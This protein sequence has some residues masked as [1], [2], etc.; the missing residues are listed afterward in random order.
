MLPT[1]LRHLHRHYRHITATITATITA[2]KK[3]TPTFTP[4]KQYQPSAFTD[5][6]LNWSPSQ[7]YPKRGNQEIEVKNRFTPYYIKEFIGKNGGDNIV[8]YQQLKRFIVQ[9][10]A[11][12]LCK[13]RQFHCADCGD[14]I[15]QV[16]AFSLCKLRIYHKKMVFH[17][18]KWNTI[19]LNFMLIIEFRN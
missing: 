13:L 4:T 3:F 10:E 15:V 12:S 7:N 6:L 8:E 16:V 1:C 5:Q 14:F 18:S 2:K 11:F 19:D 17:S 9:V